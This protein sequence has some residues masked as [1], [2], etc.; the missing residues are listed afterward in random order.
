MYGFSTGSGTG[1]GSGNVAEGSDGVASTE[2]V[3]EEAKRSAISPKEGIGCDWASEGRRLPYRYTL[4]V[5][6][7]NKKGKVVETFS[8]IVGFREIEIKQTAAK[9]ANN[10]DKSLLNVFMILY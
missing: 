5:Q 4:V 2:G 9:T 6:L 1:S 10:T 3:S 8:T 7:K